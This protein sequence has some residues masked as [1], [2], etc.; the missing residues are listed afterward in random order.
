MRYSKLFILGFVITTSIIY[1]NPIIL[2]DSIV[3]GNFS[4]DLS[5]TDSWSNFISKDTDLWYSKVKIID[6]DVYI[7]GNLNRRTILIAKY[8]SSGVK[9]W[10]YKWKDSNHQRF[11]DFTFDS[12]NNLILIGTSENSAG[13]ADIL[14]LKLNYLGELI[15]FKIFNPYNDCNMLSIILDSNNSI[16][17]SG[18]DYKYDNGVSYQ[19]FLIKL[20]TSGDFQWSHEYAISKYPERMVLDLDSMNNLYQGASERNFNL[21]LTKYNSTGSILW[22]KQWVDSNL[23]LFQLDSEENI[24]IAGTTYYSGN[25]TIDGWITKINST[26]IILNSIL[27]G[28]F[29]HYYKSD[30]WYGDNHNNI[31]YLLSN[32]YLTPQLLKFNSSLGFEWN[33]SLEDC[34][35]DYHYSSNNHIICDSQQCLYLLSDYFRS[36]QNFDI[37]IIKLN[38]SGDILQNY[39]W[40]GLNHDFCNNIE[41]DSQDNLYM[42]CESEYLNRWNIATHVNILVKNPIPYETP[43]NLE[44]GF[45]FYD[46]LLFYILGI[47]SVVSIGT[48]SSILIKRSK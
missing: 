15:W 26:G 36:Y 43:P 16:F 12:E 13:F 18:Y 31:Y 7:T 5:S 33:C 37:L 2:L 34:F 24:L 47:V 25:E 9:L 48:A 8:N 6:Q 21:N 39:S 45:T 44:L 10:S 30:L 40:G 35:Q 1:L 46:F 3:K 42:L 4:I 14:L 17:I 32:Y 19:I 29:K 27:I 41:T 28:S 23:G 20:S 11:Y 38:S 22:S